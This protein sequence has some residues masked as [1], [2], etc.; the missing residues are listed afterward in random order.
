MRHP[1]LRCVGYC[2]CQGPRG[3]RNALT[4]STANIWRAMPVSVRVLSAVAMAAV[5]AQ[6][7]LAWGQVAADRMAGASPAHDGQA[8]EW[9][10]GDALAVPWS[11]VEV[12]AAAGGRLRRHH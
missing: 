5:R 1:T 9:Q 3:T 11:L 8:G 4:P 7:G 12:H 6:G 10:V 2:L